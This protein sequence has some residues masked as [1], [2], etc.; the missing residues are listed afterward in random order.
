M[1]PYPHFP[2]TGVA[3]PA[4]QPTGLAWALWPV[5]AALPWLLPTHAEPWTTFYGEWS[6][7]VA[8]TAIAAWVCLSMPE[9]WLV[10]RWLAG[11]LIIAT[12]PLAQEAAGFYPYRGQGAW[13]FGYLLGVALSFALA[14]HVESAAP[15]RFAD[16][17]FASLCIAALLST[18]LALY[19][20]LGL[21]VL[22]V[23]VPGVGEN[24]RPLA[25]VG[26]PNNLS[27]LLVWGLVAVWWG[28]SRRVVGHAV[29]CLAAA[30]LLF[31]VALTQSRTGWVAV[32]LLVLAGWF[33]RRILLRSSRHFGAI[34][35]LGLLFAT[36]VV[37]LKYL[38]QLL[39][40]STAMS[41]AEQVETGKRP[42]I[43]RMALDAIGEHPWLGYG[44]NQ[45]TLGHVAVAERYP[46]L[47]V[48][49]AQ[50]HNLVLDLALWNGAPLAFLLTLLGALALWTALRRAAS[51][52][53]AL[54]LIG[55]AVFLIH[56]M[57]ELPHRYAFMLLPAAAMLGLALPLGGTGGGR[58][59][60]PRV[61]PLGI[62]LV[63]AGTLGVAFAE[64]REIEAEATAQRLRAARIA[65]VP[66]ERD[67]DVLVLKP[68]QQAI[69]DLR[70][71]A[72]RDMPAEQLARMER[73]ARRYPAWPSLLRYAQAL[74]L[75]GKPT[76]AAAA[77]RLL[78]NLHPP[79][80][81]RQA[82]G[83][84]A[85]LIDEGYP[86]LAAVPWPLKVP[87]MSAP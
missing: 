65:G 23:M 61:V 60:V 34:A 38:G 2:S 33:G 64:Y 86:E 87:A 67:P 3:E 70:I 31:G 46:D 48:V 39:L 49:V 68:L 79:P 29:A 83:Y 21:D 37:A 28:H 59:G 17:L 10:D 76:E 8:F 35:A 66:P 82:G 62:L 4:A 78:C 5:L 57:L 63:L 45:G 11:L 9:R 77:A 12:I 51:P 1:K 20:W 52:R 27:T 47:H 42:M 30:L 40:R 80:V 15:D 55:L 71:K 25:N 84:W 19:Q 36:Y 73:A 14:R 74:A 75:N 72:A 85:G 43:W 24:G 18:G 13:A 32:G 53:Q 50:A 44:W 58:V 41:L 7:A 16:A 56:A 54:P 26:Q 69:E 81:C 22:G 6:A